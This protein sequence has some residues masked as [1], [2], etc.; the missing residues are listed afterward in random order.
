MI[1]G[2]IGMVVQDWTALFDAQRCPVIV[3]GLV[4]GAG[5]LLAAQVNAASGPKPQPPSDAK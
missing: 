2:A 5:L 3:G 1:L 4:S